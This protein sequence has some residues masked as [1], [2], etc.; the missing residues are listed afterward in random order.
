MDWSHWT[1]IGSDFMH[2]ICMEDMKGM[3]KFEA[4]YADL[5]IKKFFIEN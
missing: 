4:T 1:I 5:N 2:N 3:K